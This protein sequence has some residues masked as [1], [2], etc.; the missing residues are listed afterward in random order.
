VSERSLPTIEPRVCFMSEATPTRREQEQLE[1]LALP[2]RPELVTLCQP[3]PPEN[4]PHT[5]ERALRDRQLVEDVCSLLVA[6]RG[7]KAIGRHC[8]ISPHTVR[9]MRDQ[10]EIETRRA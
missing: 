9:A 5:G 4:Y 10:L 7:M 3:Q 6:G 2:E 1:L 8:G